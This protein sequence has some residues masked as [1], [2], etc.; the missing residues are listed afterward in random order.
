MY[1][2]DPPA[3]WYGVGWVHRF[4][5]KQL[6]WYCRLQRI[7]VGVAVR[8]TLVYGPHDDFD[9]ASAHFVPS[10]IRRVAGLI[11]VDPILVLI[12]RRR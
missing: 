6:D 12:V 4:L 8:P 2:G 9:A 1:A 5:E 7:A 3:D 11:V 10:F